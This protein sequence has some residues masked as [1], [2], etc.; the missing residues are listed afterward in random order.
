MGA[1]FARRRTIAKKVPA[2]FQK[3]TARVYRNVERG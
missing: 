3:A 1:S 2:R